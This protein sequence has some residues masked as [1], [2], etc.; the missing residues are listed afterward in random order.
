MGNEALIVVAATEQNSQKIAQDPEMQQDF[1]E[2][3]QTLNDYV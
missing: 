1:T 3:A 2:K